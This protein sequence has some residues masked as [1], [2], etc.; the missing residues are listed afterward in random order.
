MWQ[1]SLR[2]TRATG[3]RIAFAKAEQK[4]HRL[5]DAA[6]ALGEGRRRAALARGCS[7]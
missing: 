5:A 1:T 7:G 6:W 4:F 2:S 3:G